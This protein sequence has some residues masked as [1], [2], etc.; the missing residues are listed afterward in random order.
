[1]GDIYGINEAKTD[2][3][4]AYNTG[5]V[6]GLLA[7]FGDGGFTNMSETSRAS[8]AA[9]TRT[10][11]RASSRAVALPMP[12]APLETSAFLPCTRTIPSEVGRPLMARIDPGIFSSIQYPAWAQARWIHIASS[13]IA[14]HPFPLNWSFGNLWSHRSFPSAFARVSSGEPRTLLSWLRFWGWETPDSDASPTA[15][16]ALPSAP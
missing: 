13:G 14:Q 3:R 5:D 8:T 1:M 2:L 11:S 10:P 4:E 12:E 16:S 6:D 15:P 7:V 9:K